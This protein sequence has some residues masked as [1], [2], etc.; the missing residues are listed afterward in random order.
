[1]ALGLNFEAA[2]GGEIIPIIKYDAKA[3]RAFRVDRADGVSTPVDITPNFKCVMD[4]ANIETGWIA[5]NSNTAPDFRVG[6]I[7]HDAGPRPTDQH[8]AG[9]RLLCKLSRELGGDVRE[10]AST[11][12]V[13]IN[14]FDKLHN[15]YLAAPQSKQGKLPVV[16]LE[17]TIP[18]T[19]GEGARKSTNY[20]PEF[21]IVSWVERPQDLAAK[22]RGGSA[23]S[24]PEN[25]FTS[26][27]Q[28]PSTGS[29]VVR[30]PVLLETPVLL[31]ASQEED[32]G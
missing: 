13:A 11:A 21:K 29:T 30:P 18:V 10:I 25:S 23:T 15:D 27:T 32:F 12:K 4:L 7:G 1:M 19:S 6:P 16:V 3:G 20:K 2:E 31:D 9:F 17:R 24:L 5:F 14:G 8:K 26:G 28:R 22:P